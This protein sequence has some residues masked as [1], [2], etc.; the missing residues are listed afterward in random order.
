MLIQKKSVL[1]ILL[2]FELLFLMI[3]FSMVWSGGV[4]G[5]PHAVMLVVV[6]AV[7][8]AA[9]GLSLLVELVHVSGSEGA[10]VILQVF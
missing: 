4:V 10:S 6:F 8:E 5:N 3:F 1:M 7:A 9:L 2:C